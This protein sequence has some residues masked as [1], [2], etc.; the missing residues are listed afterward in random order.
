MKKILIVD[1]EI[2]IGQ[3]LSRFLS[4]NGFEVETANSGAPGFM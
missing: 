3:L 4:R 1:D 2:D